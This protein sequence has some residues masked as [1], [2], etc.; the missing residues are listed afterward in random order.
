MS[1]SPPSMLCAQA[2][3]SG[4]ASKAD[5]RHAL[6]P[7]RLYRAERTNAAW[8]AGGQS[9]WA[10]SDLHPIPF[11]SRRCIRP[12][13]ACVI[14]S[15]RLDGE[16]PTGRTCVH[17]P[18]F[19]RPAVAFAIVPLQRGSHRVLRP[20]PSDAAWRAHARLRPALRTPARHSPCTLRKTASR[21]AGCRRICTRYQ[22]PKRT[23]AWA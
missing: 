8:R 5:A 19:V 21:I 1:I 15:C 12:S 9:R 2:E 3:T 14:A 18:S 11:C 6:P 23:R 22:S 17:V 13:H 4:S 7:S 10:R 16:E 20:A